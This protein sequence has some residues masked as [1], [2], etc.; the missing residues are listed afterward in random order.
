MAV[1]ARWPATRSP[2]SRMDGRQGHTE[3]CSALHTLPGGH[4]FVADQLPRPAALIEEDL[5]TA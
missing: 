1:T 2:P 4:F 5:L 3:A